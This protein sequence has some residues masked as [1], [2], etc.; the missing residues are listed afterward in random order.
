M[1]LYVC[2]YACINGTFYVR[3]VRIP[4]SEYVCVYECIYVCVCAHC[5]CV[6]NKLFL[7]RLIHEWKGRYF[8]RY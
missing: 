8:N 3:Y 4:V 1:C 6:V 5:T 2:L 7:A